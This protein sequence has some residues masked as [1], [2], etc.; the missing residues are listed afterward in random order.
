MLLKEFDTFSSKMG[1]VSGAVAGV[2]DHE[3]GEVFIGFDEV[4]DDLIGRGGVDVCVHFPNGEHEVTLEFG[5]VGT[6]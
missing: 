2:G 3:E 6:V 4:V 1:G 5:D